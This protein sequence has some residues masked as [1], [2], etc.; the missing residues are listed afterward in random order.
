[1]RRLRAKIAKLAARAQKL[2]CDPPALIEHGTVDVE[3]RHGAVTRCVSVS[4]TG[5]VPRLKG[6]RFVAA[7]TFL[8]EGNIIRTVPGEE[9]VP[10]RFRT[11]DAWCE[12][13]NLSRRRVRTY[14][15]AHEA[16]G[17]YLQVGS[18]CLA[19]H[20]GH[21]NPES[22]VQMA[23]VLWQVQ[24]A[25]EEAAFDPMT[26]EW[27]ASHLTTQT[28]L[29]W[30][31]ACIREHGWVPRSHRDYAFPTADRAINNMLYSR[32]EK[33][34]DR[35]TMTDDDIALAKATI[36]WV[37]S[38]LAAR[39][40]LSDYEWNLSLA[41]SESAFP[42]ELTG[43]VASAISVYQRALDQLLECGGSEYQGEIKKRALF[44][45]LALQS[46]R[47]FEGAYGVSNLHK[48]MDADGNVYV[49]W[50][51]LRLEE[52]EVYSGR[53]TVKAHEEYREVKQTVLTRCKF[54]ADAGTC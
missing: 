20:T 15:V 40:K 16:T 4:V 39:P 10:E 12:H 33:A 46:I 5:D 7:L 35:C 27:G 2:G 24:A 36:E 45:G 31:A 13:C 3:D 50:T 23:Q 28:F 17:R 32:Y 18:T 44:E 25:C 30:V 41:L 1:M 8:P 42:F 48:F 11:V 51:G 29:S 37:R 52:G 47:S 21:A 22:V 38:T 54:S 26:N 6:W 53:A 34:K 19:D 43:I 14:I 9:D 49:W